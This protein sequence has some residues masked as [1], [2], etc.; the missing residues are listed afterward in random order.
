[1]RLART[2][3][4]RA[5]VTA[6]A[7]CSSRQSATH[8]K[9]RD[10]SRFFAMPPAR[11][12]VVCIQV[13]TTETLRSASCVASKHFSKMIMTDCFESDFVNCSH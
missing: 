1:M 2:P 5:E 10:I 13:A 8:A 7:S 11:V 12:G 6:A 4:N 9:G 3:P